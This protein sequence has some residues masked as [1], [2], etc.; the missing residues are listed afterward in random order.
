MDTTE[1]QRQIK[2]LQDWKASLEN[3]WSIPLEIDQAF[4]ARFP[5]SSIVTSGKSA[6]SENQAVNEAGVATYSVLGIP[7]GF[8]QVQIGTT[9]YNLPYFL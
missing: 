6:T 1:L 2:E 4:R 7:D 9:I 3:S 5:T 8:L